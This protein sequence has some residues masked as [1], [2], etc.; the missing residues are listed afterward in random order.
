MGHLLTEVC[1]K[2]GVY[3]SPLTAA[4]IT[5]KHLEFNKS[6]VILKEDVN[7]NN[8]RSEPDT[9]EQRSDERSECYSG[10]DEPRS[11]VQVGQVS[12]CNKGKSLFVCERLLVQVGASHELF[13]AGVKCSRSVKWKSPALVT[14]CLQEKWRQKLVSS[15][16][17]KLQ[18]HRVSRG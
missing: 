17:H 9:S 7:N 6:S 8:K 1:Y 18:G 11:R 12:T 16:R 2:Y 15:Q 13:T 10:Q 3:L 5:T 14:S 4:L